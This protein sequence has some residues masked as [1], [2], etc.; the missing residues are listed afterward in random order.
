MLATNQHETVPT[1]DHAR[2][3]MKMSSNDTAQP[4]HL[5]KLMHFYL[6][7]DRIRF[8]NSAVCTTMNE[9]VTS[10]CAFIIT[11]QISAQEA[12]HV[13]VMYLYNVFAC[14]GRHTAVDCG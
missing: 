5:G 4:C 9:L 12:N 8:E 13:H 6:A 1:L 10:V 14:R 3:T 7:K 2:Q 11:Q